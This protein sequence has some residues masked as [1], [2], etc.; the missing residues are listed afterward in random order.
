MPDPKQ[1]IVWTAIPRS[2]KGGEVTVAV[3][4]SPRLGVG[5]SASRLELHQFSEFE[6]WPGTLAQKRWELAF[7]NGQRLA[8]RVDAGRLDSGL[9]KHL[10]PRRTFVRP[11]FFVDRSDAQLNSFDARAV[12]SHLQDA[13]RTFGRLGGQTLPSSGRAR[14]RRAADRGSL[15]GS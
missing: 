6:D 12:A 13:F 3:F 2:V 15:K 11:W 10:F 5:S 14:P 1:Q 7:G 9:W 8:A 4:V